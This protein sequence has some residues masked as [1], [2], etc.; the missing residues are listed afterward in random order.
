LLS[1][2]ILSSAACV[3]M[4]ITPAP[5]YPTR[6]NDYTPTT[7]NV[8]P[9]PWTDPQDY[10]Y[11][12]ITTPANGSFIQ[13]GTV[14]VAGTYAGPAATLTVNG[15]PVTLAGGAFS[16]EIE[17]AATDVVV[18]I[19]V[20]ATTTAASYVSSDLST[21]FVGAA[22]KPAGTTA[23]AIAL[24][25]ENSG[26]A[27]IGGALARLLNDIDITSPLQ[28]RVDRD[29]AGLIDITK[30]QVLGAAVVL[31]SSTA[32]LNIGLSVQTIDLQATVLG[33]PIS[34]LIDDV[35]ADLVVTL[36]FDANH[37]ATV[38]VVSSSVRI[39]SLNLSNGVL[40][41]LVSYLVG[42]A[43]DLL[44]NALV[45]GLVENLFN[46]M[47]LTI[48]ATG[49]TYQFLPSL[50]VAADRNFTFGLDGALTVTDATKWNPQ[51]QPAGYLATPA[52]TPVFPATTPLTDKAYGL[53]IGA[54][55]NALNQLLY[56]VAATN[57]LSFT[58]TDSILNAALLSVLF[59]S[60]DSI[61]PS[62]PLI[63]NLAPS[64]APLAYADAKTGITNLRLPA[65]TGQ[66]LVDRGAAGNWE[67]LT[68]A[69][70]L[71]APLTVKVNADNSF[72]L[73][74]GELDINL[75]VV[76]N[77]IGQK[78]VPNMERLFGEIFQSI[79]PQLLAGL[80]NTKI[81]LPLLAGLQISLADIAAFGAGDDYLGIFVGLN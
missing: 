76:H 81:T 30:A 80:T 35:A 40:D 22:Q 4:A 70:D 21:V 49:F 63:L 41:A 42:Q 47:N 72:S 71:T 53:G 65:Y 45:P 67:A 61:D 52:S 39:G 34:I 18:P 58:V 9:P 15:Q 54:A 57:T 56:G 44:V 1:V 50:A 29:K 3:K 24:D 78:N 62:T 2:V 43:L 20:T 19:L 60:F 73:L 13:S 68:F 17:V 46:T 26:M 6:H 25:L 36:A 66:I 28:A 8:P 5:R 74:L 37:K 11:V 16:G 32:G 64:A 7:Q 38:T 59:F 31:N 27:A 69:V 75:Q 23:D 48:T 79:L 14:A 77:A 12:A 55:N 33:L 51:F 10:P